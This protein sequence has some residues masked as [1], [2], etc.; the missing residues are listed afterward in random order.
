MGGDAEPVLHHDRS[1]L[2]DL[3]IA[4]GDRYGLI[5]AGARLFFSRWPEFETLARMV[6]ERTDL[7]LIVLADEPTLGE[8]LQPALRERLHVVSGLLPFTRLDTLISHAAIFV[9]NDSGP[10]H[11]AALRGVPVVSI[12][13]PRN[14]WSEWGQEITGTIIT[15]RVPCAGCGIAPDGTDCGKGY[16]CIRRVTPEEVFSAVTNALEGTN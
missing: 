6:L 1:T 12:H 9:G 16:P 11:L 2:A 15:R 14:N 3:G 4:A 10:K 7:K 8:G 5:H 13:I